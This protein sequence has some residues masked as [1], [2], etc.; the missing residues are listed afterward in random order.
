MA[1]EDNARKEARELAR[2]ARAKPRPTTAP[3]STADD[4]GAVTDRPRPRRAAPVPDLADP[5]T[6][7]VLNKRD[8]VARVA[9]SC[10]SSRAQIRGVVEATLSELGRAIAAGETLALPPFGKARVTRK[11][12]GKG[13]E[14]LIL[15]LRRPGPDVTED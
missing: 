1:D 12:T 9:Q 5:V 10:D 7:T 8:F 3:V 11:T 4:P 15:R 14:V 6:A 13:S 2:T